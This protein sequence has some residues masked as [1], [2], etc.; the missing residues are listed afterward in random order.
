MKTRLALPFIVL[1][2]LVLVVGLACGT[3]TT[4][5]VTATQQP[6]PPPTQAQFPTQA[7]LLTQAPLPTHAQLPTQAPTNVPAPDF[8][9]ETF[10]GDLSLW[11]YSVTIGDP[12]KFT[13]AQTSNGLRLTLDDPKLYVYY[14]YDP[15]LYQDVRLDLTFTNKGHN[16]NNINLVC[17]SSTDGRYEFTV[18]N[19]GLWQIW[20]YDALQNNYVMVADGGSTAIR[21]GQ[22]ENIV[23]ATC[24]GDALT[25]YINGVKAKSVTDTQYNFSKGQIGFGINISPSN[26]VTPVIVDIASLAISQP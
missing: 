8:F 24:I 9:T 15:Y 26:P 20:I 12:S 10:Q 5:V 7:E 16:S 21:S 17:R 3:T 4:I 2:V 23:T 18:Q 11:P 14:Y 22:Q 6:L 25:L 19:D 1:A 13:E